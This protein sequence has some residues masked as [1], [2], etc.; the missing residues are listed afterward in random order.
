M[1]KII[2]LVLLLL[3]FA[4]CKDINDTEFMQIRVIDVN[5]NTYAVRDVKT[6]QM[7]IIFNK[8]THD[9]VKYDPKQNTF[10]KYME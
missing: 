7:F 3:T 5:T 10:T 9:V 1:K 4:S 2:I 6:E 8:E